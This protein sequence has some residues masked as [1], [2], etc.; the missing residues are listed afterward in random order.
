M[1]QVGRE[2]GVRYVL[3]GSVRK[4]GERVRITGQ[5]I[6]ATTGTHVWADRFDGGLEDIFELQDRIA[7]KVASV[8]SPEVEKAEIERD[9][10][11]TAN[12]QAY[13]LFLKAKAAF[14]RLTEKDLD[15]ALGYAEKA[16]TLDPS[17]ARCHALLA[18]SRL[19]GR[20]ESR[21]RADADSIAR[22]RHRV[23]H[24]CQHRRHYHRW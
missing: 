14:D 13:D 5:L 8:I 17:F 21:E 1:R 18:Y 6:E 24:R 9:G 19:M 4:A 22:R 11:K 23:P 7:N 16:L 15:E 2:L 10:R 12:L 3:E 20:D